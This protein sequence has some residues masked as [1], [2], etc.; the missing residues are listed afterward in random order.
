MQQAPL[1]LCPQTLSMVVPHRVKNRDDLVDDDD[2]DD[3][4]RRRRRRVEQ[5]QAEAASPPRP[6][7]RPKFSKTIL[8]EQHA[9]KETKAALDEH[10]IRRL[11]RQAQ[12][13]KKKDLEDD[14]NDDAASSSSS[15]YS[16]VLSSLSE[17]ASSSSRSRHGDERD[18][19]L[20][21]PLQQDNN[22][23]Q[24]VVVLF[25]TTTLEQQWNDWQRH[26]A[27]RERLLQRILA[28]PRAGRQQRHEQQQPTTTT[29]N[30]NNTTSSSKTPQSCW[31]RQLREREQAV[32]RQTLERLLQ[33]TTS[34]CHADD[35][36]RAI[37]Q[38]RLD[39]MVETQQ[40]QQQQEQWNNAP[41]KIA[42]TRAK[43]RQRVATCRKRCF[44]WLV[45]EC[46][47]VV[48]AVFSLM[49]HCLAHVGIFDG[50]VGIYEIVKAK[51]TDE[52]ELETTTPCYSLDVAVFVVGAVLM[53]LSSDLFWW[54]SDQTYETVK[55]DLHN[56]VRL[57]CWDARLLVWVRDRSLV[58]ITFF[59]AGFSMCYVST[60]LLLSTYMKQPFDQKDELLR[61]MPSSM[62]EEA[63]PQQTLDR[64]SF[65]TK[66]CQDEIERQGTYVL[67]KTFLF[68]SHRPPLTENPFF[69]CHFVSR[70]GIFVPPRSG[71]G[72]Y[73][74]DV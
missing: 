62:M 60:M 69:F 54:L 28:A 39:V 8:A 44:D 18:G 64:I 51:I 63:V 4:I 33:T 34:S 9:G 20:L 2:N 12:H 10:K 42:A 23:Q 46:H 31:V 50:T 1:L 43:I 38:R 27:R 72:V 30:S 47:S 66:A 74:F 55:F 56:R 22:K 32:R 19:A 70:K 41:S 49:V 14:D 13:D 25:D 16:S 67:C 21:S 5:Q 36:E 57:G 58:R 11:K 24:K 40:Q 15:D 37:F 7:R 53:R 35:R 17:A 6:R 65:C 68:L 48:P 59:M 73:E 71:P 61:R 45:Y 29:D 52:W 26:F 3:D